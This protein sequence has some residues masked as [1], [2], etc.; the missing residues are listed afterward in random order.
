MTEDELPQITPQQPT[1]PPEVPKK[2]HKRLWMGLVALVVVVIAAVAVWFYF[3]HQASQQA[4]SQTYKVGILMAFTGG[5]SNMG[6]GTTK[7]IQLAKKQLNANNIELVQADSRCDPKSAKTAMQSLIDKGVVAVIGDGC[8]SASLAALPLA[9]NNKI[10]MVSPSA[11][12]TALSIPNDYFFRVIPS[13]NYQAKYM[14][15]AIRAKGITNVAV[16]YT[17]EPYGAAMNKS[18][19]EQFQTLG[20]KVVATSYAEPDDINLASEMQ[21]LKAANPEAIFIAPN[22]LVTATAAIQVARDQ[23]ITAPLFGG[24]ILYDHTLIS[25]A[26]TASNG[27]TVT[28]FPTGSSTFKQL[29]R[30]EYNVTEQLYAAPQAY[31]AFEAIY[32]AIQGGATTGEAIYHA[33]PG[34]SFQGMSANISFDENGEEPGANY[35]YDLLQVQ[36]GTFVEQ[37]Q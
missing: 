22:S 23:G 27:V 13:D 14:A 20:G 36:N 26:P 19:Q 31:D 8:S 10:P 28:T 30:N 29:L 4:K 21:K 5:S 25:N 17:N 34:I 15:Q 24:D 1:P 33:L 37:S 12:S 9:N 7:G 32:K 18:F 6:Y 11:S 16:F 35:K 3:Q 2:T